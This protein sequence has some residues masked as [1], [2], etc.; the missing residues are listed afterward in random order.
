M[1]APANPNPFARLDKQSVIGTLKAS[2]SRDPDV[3]HAQ[4]AALLGPLKIPRIAGVICILSGAFLT[5]TLIG[6]F[7]GI[8]MILFGWWFWRR[9]GKNIAAVESGY[10]EYL[11][12]LG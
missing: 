2:G 1:I 11:A 6:A 4:K 7:I 3:L 5:L 9:G 10:T 8:P 12:T